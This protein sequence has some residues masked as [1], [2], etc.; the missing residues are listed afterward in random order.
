MNKE[1]LSCPICSGE[2]HL[3]DQIDLNIS[4]GDNYNKRHE[5]TG[6]LFPLS[7][8][9]INY[10]SC[11]DCFF[12]FAPEFQEWSEQEFLEKIYN[13]DYIKVD[14]DYLEVRPQSG[15]KILKQLFSEQKHLIKHLD[16]GGGNGKLTSLLKEDGW[17]S[18]TYDPFPASNL[19]LNDLGRFN[20]ITAYEVFEHVPDVHVLMKNL[21]EVM[22]DDC[23]ILFSTMVSD[24][25]IKK[26]SRITW[27]YAAPRNGHIS[28]F[29]TKSL[30]LLST[31]YKMNFGSFNN[32]FHCFYK[33]VPS[34]AKHLIK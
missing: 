18:E 22:S 28:L 24:G 31:K 10:F 19:N 1:I 33:Q 9:L 30:A 17:D 25:N 13:D 2:T 5:E 34:W 15:F 3:Q 12:T 29:S 20:L 32:G 8:T 14:S 6:T 23:L 4:C 11:P 7:G 26:N 21:T 16:Y 27:W